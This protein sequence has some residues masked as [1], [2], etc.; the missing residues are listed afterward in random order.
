MLFVSSFQKFKI[1]KS[2]K[3]SKFVLILTN[4]FGFLYHVIKNV[5]KQVSFHKQ[6]FQKMSIWDRQCKYTKHGIDK[7]IECESFSEFTSFC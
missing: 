3:S 2:R 6:Y 1:K 5:N 7:K 4:I